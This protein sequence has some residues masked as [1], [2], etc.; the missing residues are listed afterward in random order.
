MSSPAG[1]EGQSGQL[2][3]KGV[4]TGRLLLAAIF[5]SVSE[6]ESEIL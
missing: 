2:G 6:S 5:V 3:A 4:G 1:D